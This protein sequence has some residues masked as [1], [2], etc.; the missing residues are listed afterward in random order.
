M[1]LKGPGCQGHPAW[2]INLGF[3][4]KLLWPQ[5]TQTFVYG[6]GCEGSTQH[7]DLFEMGLGKDKLAVNHK[8]P[9]NFKQNLNTSCPRVHQLTNIEMCWTRNTQST[10][11]LS[12]AVWDVDEVVWRVCS[13]SYFR[14][15]CPKKQFRWE[16]SDKINCRQSGQ[17]AIHAWFRQLQGS[18]GVL[19]L[20]LGMFL[21]QPCPYP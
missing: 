20:T 15:C 1:M 14:V 2:C 11:G 17:P 12:S 21:S 3:W 10:N 18:Q 9:A 13:K 5:I 4:H 6:H 7:R 19:C 16:G 8:Q